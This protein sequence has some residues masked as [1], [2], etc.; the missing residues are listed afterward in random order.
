M[1]KCEIEIKIEIE[2]D[3][4][5]SVIFENVAYGISISRCYSKCEDKEYICSPP[6]LENIECGYRGIGLKIDN[7]IKI[8]NPNTNKYDSKWTVDIIGGCFSNE[9]VNYTDKAKI[10]YKFYNEIPKNN[11]IKYK[12]KNNICKE[13]IYYSW[14]KWRLKY[15]EL[16]YF[17]SKVLRKKIKIKRN[18]IL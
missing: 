4:Y 9:G 1:L 16:D 8:L 15:I 2:V 5:Y 17:E 12:F 7:K 13:I 11:K 18:I 3:M 10:Y 6:K 14:Y